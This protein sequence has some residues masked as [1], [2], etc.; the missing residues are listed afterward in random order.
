MLKKLFG[1]ATD[2]KVNPAQVERGLAVIATQVPPV[3]WAALV[4]ADGL[5][6]GIF[7]S[8][9]ELG[10]DRIAAMSAAMLSLGERITGE[11]QNGGL[12]YTFMSGDEGSTLLL[13][14]N[15]KYAL[16]LG[17]ERAATLQPVLEA[18]RVDL[19]PLLE[20]LQIEGLSWL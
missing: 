6:Q 17:L 19:V 9:V 8:Q 11:L 10:A 20:T 1:S 14:L 15:Q 3:R 2:D 16:S 13:V 5:I 18:L 4:S 7:P 12:R